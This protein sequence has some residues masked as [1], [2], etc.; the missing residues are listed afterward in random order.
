MR[1]CVDPLLE[2]KAHNRGTF[3]GRQHL[4]SS[5]KESGAESKLSGNNVVEGKDLKGTV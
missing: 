5:N 4:T 3:G 2:R 1:G